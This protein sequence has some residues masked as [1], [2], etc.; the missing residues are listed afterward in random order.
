MKYMIMMFGATGAAV[1]GRSPEWMAG[2]H[3]L[4]MK[5]DTELRESGDLTEA[6]VQEIIAS[7]G[8]LPDQVETTIRI[9]EAEQ[10]RQILND[11]S[12]LIE[13]IPPSVQRHA[14][15]QTGS[16]ERREGGRDQVV[17]LA[18]PQRPD[19]GQHPTHVRLVDRSCVV[20]RDPA[21]RRT[22][23]R[24][25]RRGRPRPVAARRRAPRRAPR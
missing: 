2:F 8:L 10:A 13:G 18:V 19:V 1:A 15:D 7:L 5:L 6:Q 21:G 16:D 24:S 17:E 4:I 3:E 14:H 22:R 23:T 25:I 9:S 12:G 20:G 11:I